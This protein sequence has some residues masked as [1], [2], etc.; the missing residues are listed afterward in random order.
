M[1]HQNAKYKINHTC[2]GNATTRRNSLSGRGDLLISTEH[3]LSKVLPEDYMFTRGASNVISQHLLEYL[4]LNELNWDD[5]VLERNLFW[6]L[7]PLKVSKI[8]YSADEAG[9]LLWDER[10]I[11]LEDVLAY[12]RNMMRKLP[13]ETQGL[14]MADI[15]ASAENSSNLCTTRI[16]AKALIGTYSTAEVAV[17]FKSVLADAYV[18]ARRNDPNGIYQSSLELALKAA[19]DGLSDK[20]IAV[21]AAKLTAWFRATQPE[22][23]ALRMYR[24][25]DEQ[26]AELARRGAKGESA[27]LVLR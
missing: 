25:W 1:A 4:F 5:P 26:D 12:I 8:L 23:S 3:W 21:Q 27:Q 24:A 11:N 14:A 9:E 20:G 18:D 7:A 22:T 10:F 15:L 17:D 6:V 13:E 2:E 19:G 16:S